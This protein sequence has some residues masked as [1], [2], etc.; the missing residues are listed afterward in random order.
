MNSDLTADILFGI[1]LF[2]II[3]MICGKIVEVVD[4]LRGN[5]DKEAK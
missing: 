3:G 4:I 2:C 1:M 5:N